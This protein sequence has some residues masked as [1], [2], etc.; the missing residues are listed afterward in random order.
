MTAEELTKWLEGMLGPERVEET[1]DTVRRY[2]QMTRK[3]YP[4]GSVQESRV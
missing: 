4:H 3:E 2:T 1:I